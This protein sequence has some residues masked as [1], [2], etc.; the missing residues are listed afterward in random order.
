MRDNANAA[1]AKALWELERRWY[2]TLDLGIYDCEE[3]LA[4]AWACWHVY[5]RRYI[6]DIQ[7]RERINNLLDG[8]E[9]ATIIDLG[10]GI[11]ASSAA[12]KQA[13][14]GARVIGTNRRG[15]LQWK[16]GECL[17]RHFAFEMAES[18]EIKA[19]IVFASEYFEHFLDPVAH[20]QSVVDASHPEILICANAFGQR[21][22][23]HFERYEI[24][25]ASS[26]FDATNEAM[27][28]TASRLFAKR[29]RALSYRK[30]KTKLWNDRPSFWR[31]EEI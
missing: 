31:K 20:L 16:L 23:G 28:E 6:L 25:D 1:P 10:N 5:S 11:G 2:D 4:E 22:L 8:Y 24:P 14:P 17:A 26:M 29:L 7:K 9:R 18:A 13:F 15:S 19:D 3:Y 27:P 30:A 21:A 12:L